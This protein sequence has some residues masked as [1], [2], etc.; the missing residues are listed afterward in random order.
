MAALYDASRKT[1]S[2][3]RSALGCRRLRWKGRQL[4]KT[5]RRW[6]GLIASP[7]KSLQK[8]HWDAARN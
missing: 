8:L 1:A 5:L 7:G 4:K 6:D 2:S 3:A